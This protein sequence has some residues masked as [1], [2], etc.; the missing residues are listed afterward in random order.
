M[1]KKSIIPS[2]SNLEEV[3]SQVNY[4]VDF[5]D[6]ELNEYYKKIPAESKKLFD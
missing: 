5:G 1:S 3:I 2:I 4:T 6:E